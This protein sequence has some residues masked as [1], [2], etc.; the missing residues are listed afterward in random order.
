MVKASVWEA[1]KHLKGLNRVSS[2]DLLS[3]GLPDARL[4]L[5]DVQERISLVDDVQHLLM[6]YESR[7]NRVI[8]MLQAIELE[9]KNE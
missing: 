1:A 3:E 4:R 2:A 7:L 9:K 8:T 5:S 6:A